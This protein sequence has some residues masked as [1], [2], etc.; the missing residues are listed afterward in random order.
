MESALSL[1]LS[2][3]R[4]KR[5]ESMKKF[6]DTLCKVNISVK[7]TVENW[8]LRGASERE[9]DCVSKCVA[10]CDSVLSSLKDKAASSSSDNSQDHK[11]VSVQALRRQMMDLEFLRLRRF[12]NLFATIEY[13][14]HVPRD[15]ALGSPTTTFF[16]RRL[17]HSIASI[18]KVN[19]HDRSS[20]S[21]PQ[22]YSLESR[23][24]YIRVDKNLC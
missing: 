15:G 7:T 6:I 22:C 11:S 16:E 12:F 24:S 18:H 17:D 4:K 1:G 14:E 8:N 19:C 3:Q 2:L 13:D 9:L 20:L 23:M 10:E 5:E 21:R